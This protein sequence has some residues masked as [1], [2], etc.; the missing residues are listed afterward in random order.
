MGI[1]RKTHKIKRES[2]A[3]QDRQMVHFFTLP[4]AHVI[5]LYRL[6]DALWRNHS[7]PIG[8]AYSC[9]IILYWVIPCLQKHQTSK[10]KLL[11]GPLLIPPLTPLSS[12]P[13]IPPLSIIYLSPLSNFLAFWYALQ[14]QKPTQSTQSW[15]LSCW[16]WWSIEPSP[17]QVLADSTKS[18]P[19]C[20][21]N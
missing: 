14:L 21:V 1:K 9:V 10:K 11:T 12:S 3:Q 7:P 13:I 8:D 5:Y 20:S 18:P 16:I 4:L 19:T 6:C 15:A 2:Q 17:I